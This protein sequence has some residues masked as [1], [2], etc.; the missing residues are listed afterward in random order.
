MRKSLKKRMIL[1]SIL[2]ALMVSNE[3]SAQNG[4]FQRGANDQ[5]IREQTGLLNGNRDGLSINSNISNQTFETPIGNGMFFLFA[6]SLSYVVLKK[7]EK[8]P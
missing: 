7:K 4:L 1:L 5:T 2:A 8:R 6:A 3:V